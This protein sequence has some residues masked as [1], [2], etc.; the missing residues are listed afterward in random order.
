MAECIA[1]NLA[2]GFLA[3]HHDFCFEDD[4]LTGDRKKAYEIPYSRIQKRVEDAL[5]YNTPIEFASSQG[6]RNEMTGS[7]Q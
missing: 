5:L 1:E 7:K 6:R 3:Q 2:I 4:F